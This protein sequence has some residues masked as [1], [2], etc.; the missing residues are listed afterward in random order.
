MELLNDIKFSFYL[1]F[2]P[3]NAFYLIKSEKKTSKFF[4]PFILVALIITIVLDMRYTDFI[5]NYTNVKQINVL[6]T[7]ASVCAV[8]FIW[9][10]AN[11]CVTTLVD[12]EGS[13]KAILETTAY[14]LIPYILL[15]IPATLLS[16]FLTFDENGIYNLFKILGLIWV[17][18][19]LFFG[20]LTIHQF[21]VSKTI[22]TI[23]I[24][25]IGM[26]IIMLL[27]I[28]FFIIVQQFISF[29]YFT[30]REVYLRLS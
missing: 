27:I 22:A 20:I 3:F 6:L 10:I 30:I 1:I 11:W 29:C 23:L 7:A 26:A 24:A 12:G 14:A 4:I 19:L 15:N 9:A 13:F 25:I 28:L 21:T 5:F 16:H 8:F 2:H 18:I 17:G